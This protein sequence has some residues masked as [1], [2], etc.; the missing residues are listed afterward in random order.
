MR[1]GCQV[2]RG[3]GNI[4]GA[5]A[6]RA[7]VNG[8]FF[9]LAFIA[10]ANPKLLALDLLLI[11][12]RRPR[13]MF[14]SILAGGI[15]TGVLIGL[16][17]VL[18]LQSDPTKTQRKASG[19]VD[20]ALGLILLVIGG[21]LM[22]GLVARVWGRRPQSAKRVAKKQE[23]LANPK[24]SFAR[25]ALREPRL[26]IAALIGVVCGL[27]GAS[28]LTALHNL[29]V[30]K[31]ATSTQVVAIFVFV[32]IEFLLIIIPWLFLEL[33]PARTSDLLRRSQAWLTGHV[34]ALIAWICILLGAFLTVIGVLRLL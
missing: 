23:K 8:M 4:R 2:S 21:L 13:A 6:H 30:G 34:T 3:A 19:G 7:A 15:A 18:V 22:T 25:R 16:L 26:G 12:N 28:Y 9:A 1:E 32:I 24:D 33:W 5:H 27:P 14:A 11:E 20:L 10:A 29:R 17:D 31:Y